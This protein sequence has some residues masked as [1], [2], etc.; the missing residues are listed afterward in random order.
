MAAAAMVVPSAIKIGAS[1]I[2]FT[3]SMA[4]T[5]FYLSNNRFPWEEAQRVR[6]SSIRQPTISIEELEGKLDVQEDEHLTQS[7]TYAALFLTAMGAVGLTWFHRDKLYKYQRL[8]RQKYLSRFQK[9]SHSSG[10]S[11]SSSSSSRSNRNARNRKGR[12]QEGNNTN[13]EANLN[14][15]HYYNVLNVDKNASSAMIKRA[16]NKLALKYHPDKNPRS[17]AK[18]KFKEV[19]EAYKVLSDPKMREMYDNSILWGK[20]K[21]SGGGSQSGDSNG[22]NSGSRDASRRSKKH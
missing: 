20:V 21:P 13:V 7:A 19:V 2:I 5:G 3:G 4:V 22:S 12:R 8:L 6:P 11:S 10:S 18:E 16:Y 14:R 1:V 17:S 15:T 9:S